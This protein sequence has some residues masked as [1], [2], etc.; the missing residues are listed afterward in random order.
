MQHQKWLR[1]FG[2]MCGLATMLGIAGSADASPINYS[3]LT[4]MAVPPSAANNQGGAFTSFDISFFDPLTNAAYVAD[5]SNAAV[6]IF[7][8][9]SLSLIGRAPGFSGQQA[10]TSLSGPD[11]VLVANTGTA[12]T[13]FAGNGDS[14]LR[15]FNVANP[16]SP[17]VLFPPINTGGAFRVDEMAYSPSTH[18]LLA[19][20]NADNPAFGTLFNAKTGA[21]VHGNIV[22]PNAIGLE[23]PVWNPNT[24]TF[25][26]SVPSFGGGANPG[27]VAE[28]KP[29]GT[30]GRIYNFSTFGI[31]SCSPTGLA[32][33]A[34]GNLMVGCGNHQTQ[35]V[36]LNPAGSGS[37]VKTIAQISGSDELWYDRRTHDFFV[38]GVDAA[39]NRFFDV[40]SDTSFSL[41]DSVS[42]PNVNA[43]SITVD[44]FNG[45][46]F[47]PLEGTTAA[48]TDALC[49]LGCVAVFATQVP[50][51]PSLLLTL[52]ALLGLAG[53]GWLRRVPR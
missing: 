2:A 9:S 47:V 45:D 23:Q 1:G 15:S 30:V 49:P 31:A 44:L 41:L 4:T 6:D 16:S 27:G 5:R 43:H 17:T 19:A 3:L 7:S 32:L 36:V 18:L 11:G 34:S 8:A 46:V 22:V 50:E 48:G 12:N 53:I 37:I 38:T 33:G 52:T 51:P 29:D 42:L 28:I 20:N 25:F 24:G 26:I 13:L 40:F 39:D 14:T 35:T 21:I 10:L